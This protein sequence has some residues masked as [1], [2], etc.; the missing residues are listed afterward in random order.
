MSGQGSSAQIVWEREKTEEGEM[1]RGNRKGRKTWDIKTLVIDQPTHSENKQ[2]MIKYKGTANKPVTT[3]KEKQCTVIGRVICCHVNPETAMKFM[4]AGA[5][6][7]MTTY[8]TCI[9]GFQ[10]FTPFAKT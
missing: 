6:S 10:I 3:F 9:R 2:D 1:G 5:F 8:R 4:P 7:F